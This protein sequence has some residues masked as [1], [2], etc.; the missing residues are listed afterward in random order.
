MNTSIS[1]MA[2]SDTTLVI[3]CKKEYSGNKDLKLRTVI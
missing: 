3:N 2:T 1:M